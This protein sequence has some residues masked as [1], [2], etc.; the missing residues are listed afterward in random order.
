MFFRKTVIILFGSFFAVCALSSGSSSYAQDT[1]RESA[2]M[3]SEEE[4]KVVTVEYAE[5]AVL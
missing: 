4:S 2:N 3:T 5:D 1:N